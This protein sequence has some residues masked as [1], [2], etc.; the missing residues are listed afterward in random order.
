MKKKRKKV[1]HDRFHRLESLKCVNCYNST[2]LESSVHLLWEALLL[3]RF[4]DTDWYTFSIHL[5]PTYL[6]TLL[7]FALSACNQMKKNE[8]CFLYV[9]LLSPS[10]IPKQKNILYHLKKPAHK[11]IT[12]QTISITVFISF[13]TVFEL[14]MKLRIITW[15]QI[16]FYD[17]VVRWK[18]PPI[19]WIVWV[20]CRNELSWNFCDISQFLDASRFTLI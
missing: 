6:T 16:L 15:R 19:R 7:S 18:L 2:S 13:K 17:N 8:N 4:I 9:Y 10:N 5:T 11:P 14:W 20:F 3:I 12:E 1:T